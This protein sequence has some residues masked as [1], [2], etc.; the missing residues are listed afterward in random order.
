[1]SETAHNDNKNTI[2]GFTT[3]Q[4]YTLAVIT[5]PSESRSGTSHAAPPLYLPP[6]RARK[7]PHPPP[8]ETLLWEQPSFRESARLSNSNQFRLKRWQRPL[9][10]C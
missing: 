9:S 8:W 5:W 6:R 7:L 2:A 10:R 4:A 1:M 3:V